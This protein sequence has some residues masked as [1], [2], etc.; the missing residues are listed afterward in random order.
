M[1]RRVTANR[2][3]SQPVSREV[4]HLVGRTVA[5]SNLAEIRKRVATVGTVANSATP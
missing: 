5:Y 1:S 4:V 2:D 3:F